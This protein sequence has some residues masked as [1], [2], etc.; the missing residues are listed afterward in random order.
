MPPTLCSKER[1]ILCRRVSRRFFSRLRVAYAETETHHTSSKKVPQ[2]LKS[3][4]AVC[5]SVLRF[6]ELLV[7]NIGRETDFPYCCIELISRRVR[8]TVARSDCWSRNVCPH[9][10]YDSEHAYFRHISYLGLLLK[11]VNTCRFGLK[12]GKNNR[13]VAWRR[14]YIDGSVSLSL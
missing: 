14:T 11:S 7:A 2:G 8:K 10:R 9:G 12:W 4:F 13:H 5:C 3:I 1:T 6:R